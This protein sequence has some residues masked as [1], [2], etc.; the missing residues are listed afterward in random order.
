MG[1]GADGAPAGS[2]T[3]LRAAVLSAAPGAAFAAL[4]AALACG[5]PAPESPRPAAAHQPVR[6]WSTFNIRDVF[7][8][9]PGRELVLDNCQ[10]CH[11][12]VPI[13]ILPLDEAAWHRNS[14]EHRER[15][16]GLDDDDFSTLY[17]YL[18]TNFTPA[19]PKPELPPALLDTWTTY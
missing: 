3:F 16:E 10:S 11:V 8:A 14:I 5:G 9:G 7:P 15:V 6:D 19:T 17:D 2:R 13:L 18:A 12:L 4:T 1:N